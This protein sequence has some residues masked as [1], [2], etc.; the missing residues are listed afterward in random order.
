MRI[1]A[2]L[3]VLKPPLAFLFGIVL[4]L[5]RSCEVG[6]KG[7]WWVL[8]RRGR[9]AVETKRRGRRRRTAY[10]AQYSRLKKTRA[11]R[12]PWPKMSSLGPN[13]APKVRPVKSWSRMHT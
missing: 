4:H 8:Q 13:L 10:L 5:S 6:K 3:S 7:G 2:F 12:E 11:D 9:G 1:D